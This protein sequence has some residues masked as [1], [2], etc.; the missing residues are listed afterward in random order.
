VFVI[1]PATSGCVIATM[2]GIPRAIRMKST[3]SAAGPAEKYD[4]QISYIILMLTCAF[5]S[6]L[7]GKKADLPPSS[8]EQTMHLNR[9]P[10]MPSLTLPKIILSQNVVL[11]TLPASKSDVLY[12]LAIGYSKLS[13][14]G[15][16]WFIAARI[17]LSSF[18]VLHSSS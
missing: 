17:A 12:A 18:G 2:T 1:G 4:R 8:A 15:R 7:F 10:T 5:R 9:P 14:L 6:K 3:T 16:I 13:F 11:L